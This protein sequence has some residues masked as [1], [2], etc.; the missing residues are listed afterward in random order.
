MKC[1]NLD[2][3]KTQLKKEIS[4][5]KAFAEAWEKVTFPTKKDGKP[6]A[7]LSK[8]INGAKVTVEQYALQSGENELTVYTSCKEC[9]YINDSIKLYELVRYL[10]DDGM[11]AKTENYMPKQSY[12]EQVYRYDLDDIKKAVANRAKYYRDRAADL[13]RQDEQA[14]RIF[15]KFRNSYAEAVADLEDDTAQFEGR[16]LFYAVKETVL[17]RFPYC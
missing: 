3:I 14:E 7:I 2:E 10:K 11:K 1:Y 13:E 4:K 16:F 9:G 8:N 5:S 17:D 15:N 12:L 6:F